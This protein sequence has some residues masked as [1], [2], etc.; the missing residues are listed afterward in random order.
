MRLTDAVNTRADY[1]KPE[2]R[3]I[4]RV[5]AIVEAAG[6]TRW[7]RVEE[8]IEFAHRMGFKRLGIAFC[9]GMREEAKILNAILKANGFEVVSAACKTGAIPKEELGLSDDQKVR[10]GT[11]EMMCNPIGQAH[12]LNEAQ[13]EF[14]IIFGLCVGHDSLFIKHADALTTCL[15]AKDRAL[16]HNPI[17]GIYCAWGYYRDRMYHQHRQEDSPASEG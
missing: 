15:V 9:V 2:N 6:Y 5:S 13:T 12:L 14:N 1:A 7:N 11:T 4:G 8:T 16:A 10:P 3:E 17:G